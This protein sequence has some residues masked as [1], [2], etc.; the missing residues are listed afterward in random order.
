M[1]RKSD[2]TPTPVAVFN[3]RYI[4]S[5]LFGSIKEVSKI[6]GVVRQSII[7]AVYGDTI[8]VK[9][10]YLRAI[11][12]D[13]VVDLDDIGSLT[14]FKFDNEAGN[15]DRKIYKSTRMGKRSDIIMQSEHPRNKN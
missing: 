9:G 11:P 5:G 2:R 13:I 14:L 6:T 8:S 10:C 1:P 7:K 3:S 4:L 12:E 15:P